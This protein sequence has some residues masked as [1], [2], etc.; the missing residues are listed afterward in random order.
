MGA[1]RTILVVLLGILLFL[2]PLVIWIAHLSPAWWWPFVAW[3]GFIGL[4]ALTT[5]ERRDP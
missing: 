1:S 4:I 3:G 2:S 5:G